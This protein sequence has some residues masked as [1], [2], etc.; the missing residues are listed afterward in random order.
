[1][2]RKTNMGTIL[3][4][5]RRKK[6]YKA[7]EVSALLQS[8][9]GIDLKF[10]SIY[11]YET[12]RTFPDTDVFLALCMLYDCYDILY[13]FGYTDK[14]NISA[15]TPP[16]DAMIIKKYHS[17]PAGGQSV[18]MNALGIRRENINSETL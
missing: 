14:R 13:D 11:S 9:Y 16:E 5:L 7:K 17:L 4:K 8:E 3:K 1:M 10:K 18:I 15:P 2:D 6:G 12:G